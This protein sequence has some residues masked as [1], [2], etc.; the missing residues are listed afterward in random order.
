MSAGHAAKFLSDACACGVGMVTKPRPNLLAHK[1][2]EA[3]KSS[4]LTLPHQTCSRS[5]LLFDFSMMDEEYI[6]RW[7]D[8]G[9]SFF[10]LAEDLLQQEL[11]TDVTIWC[12]DRVFDAHRLVLCA[13]SPL[14]KSMLTRQ[15]LQRSPDP[16]VFLR[17]VS[18]VHF[19]RLLQF[20]YCGEVRVPNNE[21]EDLLATA[22]SLSVR[23]LANAQDRCA[24]TEDTQQP[25]PLLKNKT[26]FQT[27]LASSGIVP[28]PKAHHHHNNHMREQQA[29]LSMAASS[30]SAPAAPPKKRRISKDS[31]PPSSEIHHKKSPLSPLDSN[32]L[33]MSPSMASFGETPPPL[34]QRGMTSFDEKFEYASIV[35]FLESAIKEEDEPVSPPPQAELVVPLVSEQPKNNG[36]SLLAASAAAAAALAAA[37]T[38]AAR[39]L[40]E[41][42][43]V[44]PPSEPRK[45]GTCYFCKKSFMKN[46]QLMNHVCPKKPRGGNNSGSS[47]GGSSTSNNS[48]ISTSFTVSKA[49]ASPT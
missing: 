40:S 17:D 26:T 31:A 33:L 23:G 18:A 48:P 37:S 46:K 9:V 28:P 27:P 8:H 16:I 42:Q 47:G 30:P 25:L 34:T 5:Q 49:K 10:A 14:F 38:V 35:S 4:N 44:L 7:N 41:T 21:L 1:R 29:P 20:M 24:A 43:R 32:R 2:G 11:L 36:R 39:T 13:C 45:T 15:R 12:G 6:L 22:T 3:A 19:E